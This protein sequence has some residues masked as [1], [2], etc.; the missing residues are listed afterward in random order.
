M[1]KLKKMHSLQEIQA[2]KKQKDVRF[3]KLQHSQKSSCHALHLE[4]GSLVPTA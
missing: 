4:K 2:V 3:S 1:I